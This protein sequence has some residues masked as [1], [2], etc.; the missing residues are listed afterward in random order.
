ME[1]S[2]VRVLPLG[3]F[4]KSIMQNQ[5]EA[6]EIVRSVMEDKKSLEIGSIIMIP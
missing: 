2:K 4:W 6:F 1:A 5:K 3:V